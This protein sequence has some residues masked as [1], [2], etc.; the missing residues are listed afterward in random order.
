M[1]N[2]N[3]LFTSLLSQMSSPMMVAPTPTDKKFTN[4]ELETIFT[5]ADQNKDGSV[6]LDE[7]NGLVKSDA[8]YTDV[9]YDLA[10]M[11]QVNFS[12]LAEGALKTGETTQ[13]GRN[14]P[15]KVSTIELSELK[16]LEGLDG[17]T[18]TVSKADFDAMKNG[19]TRNWPTETPTTGGGTE[20]DLLQLLQQ[21]LLLLLGGGGS[22]P[23]SFPP[24]YP[25]VYPPIGGY[26]PSYPPAYPPI[27]GGF[28]TYPQ[29]YPPIGG[30][31]PTYPQPY[32][33]TVFGPYGPIQL[34]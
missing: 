29:P 22:Y 32:P 16:K 20:D 17:D 24:S 18:T 11:M 6:T 26:P 14:T 15:A 2:I 27:G 25:P 9:N 4:T 3:S 31:F 19:N 12:A 21:L 10:N 5:R 1:S 28:P 34:F 8:R 7:M 23:P 30:G 33:P 13:V